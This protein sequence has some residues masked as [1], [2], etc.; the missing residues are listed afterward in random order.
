MIEPI[1]FDPQNRLLGASAG[2]LSLYGGQSHSGFSVH[3]ARDDRDPAPATPA[4]GAAEGA[5]VP[6]GGSPGLA[7]APA[8]IDPAPE[9]MSGGATAASTPF[10]LAPDL[11]PL[12]PAL[13]DSDQ[14][15]ETPVVSSW[16]PIATGAGAPAFFAAPAAPSSGGVAEDGLATIVSTEVF[17]LPGAAGPLAESATGTVSLTLGAVDD[18]LSDLAGTDPLG[19]VATLVSLVSVSDM[20]DLHPVDAPVADVP[21]DLGLGMLDTLIGD[22]LLPDALLGAEGHHD[23]AAIGDALDH[24]LGL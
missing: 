23:G 13:L 14:A 19:G 21:A 12:H 20:F 15:S 10:L 7:D 6:D 2:D 17:H 22:D 4:S 18:T 1:L 5:R 9:P 11:P 8:S 24:A 16:S 3:E